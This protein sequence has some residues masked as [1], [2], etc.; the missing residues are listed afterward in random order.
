M[1]I[2]ESDFVRRHSG[3]YIYKAVMYRYVYIYTVYSLI[4]APN[5]F[6]LA[7]KKQFKACHF[8]D[9]LKPHIPRLEVGEHPSIS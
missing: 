9:A 7:S 6:P 2:V 5:V 8:G 3:N 4:V 1:V